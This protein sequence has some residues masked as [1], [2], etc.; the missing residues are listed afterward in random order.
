MQYEVTSLNTKRLLAGSLRKFMREKSFSKI[1]VSEICLDCGVNRKTFYY[2]FEDIYALLKWILDQEASIIFENCDLHGDF[3]EIILYILNY[4]D[5]NRQFLNSIY[6]SLGY[7]GLREFLREDFIYLLSSI[8]SMLEKQEQY[9]LE[10]D[11]H[12]FLCQFYAGALSGILKDFLT[13]L[14]P[15]SHEE[16]QERI[17]Q[18]LETSLLSL[19]R[20][21]GTKVS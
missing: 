11:F 2:H 8:I 20:A 13:E 10:P 3:K 5:S 18:T 12:Q 1:T 16:I 4:I 19:I 6:D 17:S 21:K 15:K 9:Y 7:D 14:H